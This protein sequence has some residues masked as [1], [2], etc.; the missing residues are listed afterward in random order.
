MRIKK[1]KK[2]FKKKKDY[3]YFSKRTNF[4]KINVLKYNKDCDNITRVKSVQISKVF[5]A[6]IYILPINYC[7]YNILDMS[8]FAGKNFN[9]GEIIEISPTVNIKYGNLD[10]N[11]LFYKNDEYGAL[12]LG[13]G[14]IYKHSND[15]NV[16]WIINGNLNCNLIIFYAIKKIKKNGE[17][18][19]NYNNISSNFK[20]K[21]H[22]IDIDELEEEIGD[23]KL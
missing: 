23:M 11:L 15:E 4:E 14:S 21:K 9:V 7:I 20:R 12:S 6:N 10:D 2:K 17:L 3:L 1:D 18:F 19:I 16:D 8:V 13:Y 22:N 5:P